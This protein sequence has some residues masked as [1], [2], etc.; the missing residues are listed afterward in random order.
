MKNF[1]KKYDVRYELTKNLRLIPWMKFFKR[2]K[3]IRNILGLKSNVD[4]FR[5][6]IYLFNQ[7]IYYYG[8]FPLFF[9][10][11]HIFLGFSNI[12]V[13]LRKHPSENV[14]RNSTIYAT[15]FF[16]NDNK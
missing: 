5:E 3:N 11:I 4:I 14:P 6:T 10:R 13:Q 12:L 9:H 1:I 8:L 2:T 7:T 16:N 15:M